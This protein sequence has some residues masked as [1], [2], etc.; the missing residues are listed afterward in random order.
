MEW[1]LQKISGSDHGFRQIFGM[2][3]IWP[4][5]LANPGRAMT[6]QRELQTSVYFPVARSRIAD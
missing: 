1:I 3:L 4:G 6:L 2:A 5:Y